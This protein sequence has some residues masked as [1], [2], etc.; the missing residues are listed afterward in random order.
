MLERGGL[1]HKDFGVNERR[2]G[3]EV[4]LGSGE[5]CELSLE[6]RIE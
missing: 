5:G 3:A 1:L 2:D 4:E 6:G